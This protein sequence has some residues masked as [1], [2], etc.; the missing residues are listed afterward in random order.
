MKLI[1]KWY[2]FCC[3]K[4]KRIET[5]WRNQ[6]WSNIVTTII[7]GSRLLVLPLL[8]SHPRWTK[9]I[10]N[11]RAFI[12]RLDTSLPT[13]KSCTNLFV[14]R[15]KVYFIFYIKWTDKRDFFHQPRGWTL[16]LLYICTRLVS[17]GLKGKLLLST[18]PAN[19]AQ[20]NIQTISVNT[21][22]IK[23]SYLFFWFRNFLTVLC[24]VMV[25]VH[26][27]EEQDKF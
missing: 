6:T 9:K 3:W 20:I 2:G 21:S 11:W 27:N 26:V 15:L 10:R 7:N 5:K 22:C 16:A 4:R 1:E 19:K 18:L 8:R 17:I 25:P 23:F 12:W 24:F 14:S 13:K